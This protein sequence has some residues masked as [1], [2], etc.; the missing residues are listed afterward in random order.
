MMALEELTHAV[1]V[2]VSDGDHE[3]MIGKGGGG[4]H[5]GTAP[6]FNP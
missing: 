4:F 3:L 5:G 2:A 1:Q 6:P